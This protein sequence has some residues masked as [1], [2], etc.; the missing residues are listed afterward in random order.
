MGPPSGMRYPARMQ[1]RCHGSGEPAASVAKRR[2]RPSALTGGFQVYNL[3]SRKLRTSFGPS[4]VSTLS[5]WNWSP[6]TGRVR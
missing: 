1:P 5:G 2:E 4:G 6:T 3:P